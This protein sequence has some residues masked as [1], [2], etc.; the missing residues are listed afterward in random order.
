[1]SQLFY[2]DGIFSA[3][4]PP[5][6]IISSVSALSPTDHEIMEESS[7]EG[8]NDGPKAVTDL[9]SDRDDANLAE[10]QS[11]ASSSPKGRNSDTGMIIIQGL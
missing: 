7:S 5:C 8:T 11:F 3:N 4:E 10:S 2:Y 6:K 1:M 9:I